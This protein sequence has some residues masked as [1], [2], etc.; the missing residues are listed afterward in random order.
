MEAFENKQYPYDFSIIC[1]VYNAELYIDEFMESIVNQTIGF[2]EHVQLIFVDDGSPDRCGE[3]CEEYQKQYPNNIKVIH[4][5]NGG[6]SR[7]RMTGI[8][9]ATGR[10]VNFCDPDDKLSLN[11][12]QAVYDFFIQH[13]KET[14]IVSIPIILFGS[15][16]GPHHLN[17]KFNRGSRVINVEKEYTNPQLSIAS[18]F[19][20]NEIAQTLNFNPLLATAEDAEQIAKLLINNHYLGVVSDCV[21]YYRRYST[22]LVAAAPQKKEWYS[23]FLRYF[24]LE[25]IR[26]AEEK[27]GYV[28][29]FI[30]HMLMT[31]LQWKF[32]IQEVPA[33]LEPEEFDEF[34]DLLKQCISKI[35]NEVIMRQRSLLLDIK[36]AILAMKNGE[37]SLISPAVY[38]LYYGADYCIYHTF[39]KSNTELNFLEVDD[40]N[41]YLSLRQVVLCVGDAPK[42]IYIT[43]NDQKVSAVEQDMVD[44]KKSL[45][46][47]ISRWLIG[48]FVIPRALF[49]EEVNDIRVHTVVGESDIRA[50]RVRCGMFFPVTQRYNHAYCAEGGLIFYWNRRNLNVCTATKKKLHTFEKNY[51]RELWRSGKLGA[52][53]AFI[54]RQL[55]A[56]YKKEKKKKPI[57]IISDRLNKAG[58]NGEAFFRYLKSI[59]FQGAD[60]YYAINKGE[61]FDKLKPLGNVIDRA[62]RHYKFLF[63]KCDKIISS[64][65]DD[66]VLN[67]FFDYYALYQ[68][69][70]RTKDF[71]F[72][73]HGVTK[74]DISGWLNKYNKNIKGFICAAKPEHRS[75]IETPSYFYTEK[76]TWLT[77][78]A[79]FDRL[80]HDEKRYITIMPTWRRYLMVTSDRV[81][82]VWEGLEG[83]RDSEYFQFYNRLIND[84]RLLAA[85][86]EYNYQIC[87][88]PHPNIITN[89][90]LFDHHP[91]VKFF[92][93]Q[94]EYRDVYA[95]SDLVLSDYSSAVFDFAYMRKPVVYT[96]FDQVDFFHGEHV[97]TKGYFDYERDGFGEVAYDYDSTVDLLIEYMKNGCALKPM[98]RE[99]IDNFFAFNDQ[100][101]CQRILDRILEMDKK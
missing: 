88:M 50:A 28:P 66:F 20:K 6:L 65:A 57:W 86:R 16:S 43:V 70:L 53:K 79:R 33:V 100:N 39:S 59:N 74:D 80:Y 68:D 8:P 40:E 92:S 15:A 45:G 14:N 81:T 41:V 95:N 19:V 34:M 29:R 47:V 55:V 94:D 97:Y 56:G 63:L 85:A 96:Q 35:D 48:K 76:E 54:V 42:E 31:D 71:I 91:E 23:D 93:I 101:N 49:T 64:H 13:E 58:D 27:C 89:I 90:D 11:A 25:V 77:G 46:K 18:S 5:E 26:Y 21:Y 51:R 72:L 24:P 9:H 22:S 67:P 32:K 62:S 37:E 4:R 38:D 69:L 73:Q 84:E 36:I 87:Y 83:F 3:I 98:Y 99:R 78:F 30:Q 2:E 61:D 17:Y 82:G 75:I 60:Y 44:H 1:S 52:K 7:A 10:Y 12:L